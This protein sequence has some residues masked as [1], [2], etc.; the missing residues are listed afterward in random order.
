MIQRQQRELAKQRALLLE[1]QRRIAAVAGFGAHRYQQPPQMPLGDVPAL[2]G[3]F[4]HA[5]APLVESPPY[6]G[7]AAGFPFQRQAPAI[8]QDRPRSPPRARSAQ[9]AARVREALGQPLPVLTLPQGACADAGPGHSTTENQSCPPSPPR[10]LPQAAGYFAGPYRAS[11]QAA[12]ANALLRGERSKPRRYVDAE[13][14]PTTVS[15]E[16]AKILASL[17]RLDLDQRAVADF[18]GQQP[19]LAPQAP[20]YALAG[21]G[22]YQGGYGDFAPAAP[23]MAAQPLPR[24]APVGAVRPEHLRRGQRPPPPASQRPPPANSPFRQ[25]FA[26]PGPP[27]QPML[28]QN[29]APPSLTME[30]ALLLESLER[31]DNRLRCERRADVPGAARRFWR[32]HSRSAHANRFFS[33]GWSRIG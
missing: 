27:V 2:T 30:E 16:E 32:E 3:A 18:H 24:S 25:Q 8:V 26:P 1:Q 20:L 13:G 28:P 15:I 19:A 33:A 4:A 7:G 29:P 22:P 10:L 11:P 5:A 31:L 9:P 21:P 23:A 6:A 17:A 12:A 14:H